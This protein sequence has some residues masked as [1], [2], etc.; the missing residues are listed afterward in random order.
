MS[1]SARNNA[2]A[3][4]Q[5]R[6]SDGKG[7]PATAA[8]LFVGIHASEAFVEAITREIDFRASDITNAFGVNA[9]LHPVLFKQGVFC[10]RLVDVFHLVGQAGAAGGLDAQA[11]AYAFAALLEIAGDMA[12]RSFANGD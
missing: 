3:A 2:G 6:A 9:D 11:K 1:S 12:R 10:A 4:A 7:F 5:S 8:G